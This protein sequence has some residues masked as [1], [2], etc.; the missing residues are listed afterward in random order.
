M[1]EWTLFKN[2]SCE[3]SRYKSY[4][5][6]APAV[7]GRG[8]CNKVLDLPWMGK[9]KICVVGTCDDITG[10]ELREAFG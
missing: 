3:T 6:G 8:V 2:L 1:L 4:S 7:A 5:N 9:S 10:L